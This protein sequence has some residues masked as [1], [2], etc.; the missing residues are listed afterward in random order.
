MV[1]VFPSRVRGNANYSRPLR[2][3][4]M[5]TGLGLPRRKGGALPSWLTTER[6]QKRRLQ[7]NKWLVAGDPSELEG[8]TECA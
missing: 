7:D 2:F 3:P 6:S 4:T 5:G 8:G 1:S